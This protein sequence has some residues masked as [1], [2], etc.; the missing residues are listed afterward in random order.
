MAGWFVYFS[1]ILSTE[2]LHVHAKQ[3]RELLQL[4]FYSCDRNWH[5]YNRERPW[6][7]PWRVR[8]QTGHAER[9]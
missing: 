5:Y 6:W 1:S 7:V 8:G 2:T 9:A 4:S 3:P